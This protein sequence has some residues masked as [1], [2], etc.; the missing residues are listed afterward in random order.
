M[1]SCKNR[2]SKGTDG[3]SLSESFA[4]KTE[5]NKYNRNHPEMS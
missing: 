4:H 2:F 1:G 3:T 5:A